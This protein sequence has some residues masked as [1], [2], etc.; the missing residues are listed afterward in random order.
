MGVHDLGKILCD[1]LEQTIKICE[2]NVCM[3]VHVK[4]DVSTG[5]QRH[6]IYIG[7]GSK[8]NLD[9]VGSI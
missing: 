3:R 7:T 5:T 4:R 9:H 2:G 1:K 8:V 6:T